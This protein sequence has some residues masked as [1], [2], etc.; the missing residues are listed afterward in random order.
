MLPTLGGGGTERS[1]LNLAKGLCEAGYQV[2]IV[3][4]KKIG[5]YIQ[6]V[7]EG[8][9]LIDLNAPRMGATL[10]GLVRY[11]RSYRPRALFTGLELPNIIAVMA[12]ILAGRKTKVIISVRSV[13][14]QYRRSFLPH[15]SLEKA[16]MAMILPLA[17]EIVAVSQETARDFSQYLQISPSRICVIYNP[18]ITP[19]L[20]EKAQQTVDH[21]WLQADQPPLIMSAGRLSP[22]KGFSTLIKAFAHVRKHIPAR[23]MILGEGEQRQELEGLIYHLGLQAEAS[24]PGFQQNPYAFMKHAAVFVLSSIHDASPNVLIEAMACGC[25]IVTTNSPGGS[26]ELINYG[27]FGHV[28]PVGDELSLAQA[29]IEAIAGEA[30][31]PPP[32]WLAQFEYQRVIQQYLELL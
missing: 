7:P 32:E 27:E 8:I 5:D 17:D 3:L 28:A 23:L 9:T 6:Q 26:A 13:T 29:I 2:D 10:P 19:A 20:L 30:R 15:R 24:L 22:V 12:N 31:K 21:P 16:L 11:L 14:S 1:F 4:K 25:S 18:T